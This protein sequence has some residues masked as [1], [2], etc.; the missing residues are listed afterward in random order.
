MSSG[1]EAKK[2]VMFKCYFEVLV[3]SAL[4]RSRKVFYGF[5]E[6]RSKN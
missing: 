1:S 3:K 6:L 5:G 4:M 2:K